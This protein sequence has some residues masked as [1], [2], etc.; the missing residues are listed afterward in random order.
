MAWP[1]R[2]CPWPHK[3]Q[4]V[5]SSIL[6]Q[7][8]HVL[9]VTLLSLL[10]PLS[11]LLL[12]RL[13]CVS[14]YSSVLAD[15]IP[16]ILPFPLSFLFNANP[17]PLHALVAFFTVCTLLHG[18]TG[19]ITPLSERPLP[20]PGTAFHQARLPMAW[21]VLCAVQVCVGLGI[22]GSIAAGVD[23]SPLRLGS[24]ERSLLSKAIFFLGLHET[25]AY[26]SRVVVRPVADDTVFGGPQAEEGLLG[27]VVVAAGFGG[28]WWWRLRGE[29]DAMVVVPEVKKELMMGIGVAD[30][31]GWWLYYLTVTIGM[32]RIVK[33]LMW[34]GI[35]LFCRKV[36][37]DLGELSLDE[38][39]V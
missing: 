31:A 32:V 7:S 2:R 16:Q 5:N 8:F 12:A 10:L 21:A 15:S 34:V 26:W 33:G 4:F 38:E 13:A 11:F 9:T 22:E 24:A 27:R 14:Y 29:V 3:P 30:F 17:S 23:G 1:S 39:I 20:P 28:L 37:R 19:R 6:K 25:T 18:L 35:V 36:K